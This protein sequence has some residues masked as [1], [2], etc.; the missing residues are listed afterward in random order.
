MKLI[1]NQIKKVLKVK[2]PK[3]KPLKLQL[4]K[5]SAEIVKYYQKKQKNYKTAKIVNIFKKDLMNFKKNWKMP[6]K[7]LK[8]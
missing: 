2:A 6:K 4:K 7:K 8:V 3:K 5:L 1:K